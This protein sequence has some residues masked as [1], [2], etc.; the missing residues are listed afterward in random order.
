[1]DLRL[2]AATPATEEERAAV[3]SVLWIAQRSSVHIIGPPAIMS[4]ASVQQ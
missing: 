1:M 2:G 4:S 3:A